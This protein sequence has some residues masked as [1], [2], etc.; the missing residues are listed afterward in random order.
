MSVS[1]T[2]EESSKEI[3]KFDK[4]TTNERNFREEKEDGKRRNGSQDLS[5]ANSSRANSP[6]RQYWRESTREP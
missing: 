1:E 6:L 3:S 5:W 4:S 2:V